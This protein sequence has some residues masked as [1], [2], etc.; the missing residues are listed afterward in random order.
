MRGRPDYP[1]ALDAWLR[2]DLALGP[3]TVVVD[4]GSGTGKFLPRLL[5]VGAEVIAVEPS[6]AMRAQLMAN[7]PHVDARDG[8]AEAIPLPDHSVDAVVCAQCFHWFAT[9]RAL[10]EIHRVLKPG[11]HLG[12]VWNI[13][14]ATTPWVARL[15]EIMAPYDP[16]TPDFESQTWRRAFPHAG[17]SALREHAFANPQVGPAERVIVDRVRSVGSI[18]SLI[19][20]AHAQV[21]AQ[22]RALIEAT[23]ALAGRSEVLFPNTTYAF[24]CRALAEPF[25]E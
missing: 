9:E 23:P 11:G 3:G 6:S 21:M 24:D 12:L 5:A 8:R 10:T 4:L 15:I 25:Q 1:E 22:V 19:A 14:D 16:G 13:R 18:A 2:Q 20:D 17:F 7:F